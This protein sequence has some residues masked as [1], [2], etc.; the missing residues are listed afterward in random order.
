[1]LA[2]CIDLREEPEDEKRDE[3]YSNWEQLPDILLED[4]FS[5]LL[6]RDRYNASLVCRNWYRAFKLPYVWSTFTLA[7][8]TLTR[9]KYNYYS[10]WQY[11]LDETRTSACLNKV[12][13]NI[14][15]LI[16]EPMM[17]F[18]N[19]FKF[20]VMISCY[21]ERQVAENRSIDDIGSRIRRFKFTFPCNMGNKDNPESM[22]L[23][24]TGGNMLQ[25][26]KRV[27]MN[28]ENLK[29]L[30]LID[31]MLDNKEAEH[32]MDDICCNCT[33]TLSK[34]VL[35]NVTKLYCPIL[36]VGVFLNLHVS[37]YNLFKF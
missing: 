19:L 33:E 30:E 11:V 31:L 29:C 4:I 16:F 15:C 14:K 8:M 6:I 22:R 17:S 37:I 32:L 26:L 24:G 12:G 36:H 5:H 7:D 10:G 35:I 21:L 18:D 34:L 23:F 1:M 3:T 25:A 20:M 27:M 13:K 9:G 28:F 2:L